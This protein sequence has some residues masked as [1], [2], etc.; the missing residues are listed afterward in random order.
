MVD[1]AVPERERARE[2]PPEAFSL[3]GLMDVAV[4]ELDPAD[5]TLALV[6]DDG[7]EVPTAGLAFQQGSAT[8]L[9]R[10][11]PADVEVMIR[12]TSGVV[13]EPTVD[14]E[15][16]IASIAS[17]RP[18]STSGTLTAAAVDAAR[19]LATVADGRRQLVVMTGEASDLLQDEARS[20]LAS[21][22]RRARRSRRVDGRHGRPASDTGRPR[23][24]GRAAAVA[25]DQRPRCE[26]SIS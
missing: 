15:A 14:R 26:P 25:G 17:T 23:Q 20:L 12:T 24:W 4:E 11:L 19:R 2:M 5:L 22:D 16:A 9:M 8:E 6:L 21:L 13:M 3:P 7:H 10:L 1:V 18:S